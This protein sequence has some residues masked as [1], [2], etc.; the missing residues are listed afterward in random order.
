MPPSNARGD[1]ASAGGRGM[2]SNAEISRGVSEGASAR[3]CLMVDAVEIGSTRGRS[4]SASRFDG[5]VRLELRGTSDVAERENVRR[6]MNAEI[7]EGVSNLRSVGRSK[8]DG[9]R[10]GPGV[11]N[12]RQPMMLESTRS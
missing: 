3:D 2:V 12:V 4:R 5:H 10:I 7:D 6:S 1:G 11:S 9:G 8:V